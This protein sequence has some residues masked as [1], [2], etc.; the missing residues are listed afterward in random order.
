ME[1][2]IEKKPLVGIVIQARMGSSRLPGKVMKKALGRPLLDW[3]ID[4][5]KSVQCE[6]RMIIATTYNPSDDC[7]ADL[8]EHKGW[9]VCAA[10]RMIRLPGMYR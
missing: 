10:A 5:L 1:S 6:G 7:I 3:L 4:R 2:I 9:I 8:R